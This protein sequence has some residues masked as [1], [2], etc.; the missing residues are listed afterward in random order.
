M[1][2]KINFLVIINAKVNPSILRG[3]F[4]YIEMYGSQDIP[5]WS[6]AKTAVVRIHS[7][8]QMPDIAQEGRAPAL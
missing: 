8:R 7:S 1:P 4:Y 5:T 2:I 3:V 6:G